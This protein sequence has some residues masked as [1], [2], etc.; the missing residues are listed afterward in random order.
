[1][2]SKDINGDYLQAKYDRYNTNEELEESVLIDL[3]YDNNILIDFDDYNINDDFYSNNDLEKAITNM[4]NNSRLSKLI[5]N[6][7]DNSLQIMEMNKY[8]VVS[9]INNEYI[10]NLNNKRSVNVVIGTINND[11]TIIKIINKPSIPDTILSIDLLLIYTNPAL[12]T[13]PSEVMWENGSMPSLQ[14]GWN[15]KILLRSYNSGET[16]VAE[17]IKKWATS[18]YRKRIVQAAGGV[19]YLDSRDVN[20]YALGVNDPLTTEWN[21]LMG[22][23]ADV[24]L[25][26]FIGSEANGWKQELVNEQILPMLSCNG[27]T[28]VGVITDPTVLSGIGYDE[29]FAIAMTFRLNPGADSS[30]LF[31]KANGSDA[32]EF[33]LRWSSSTKRIDFNV[34]NTVVRSTAPE[35][36]DAGTWANVIFHRDSTGV[37]KAYLNQKIGSS[38]GTYHTAFVNQIY[39]RLGGRVTTGGSS[40]NERLNGSIATVTVYRGALA[41]LENV[42]NT[43]VILSKPY[44][45]AAYEELAQAI[46]DSGIV[47]G[48]VVV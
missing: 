45:D 42:L 32:I 1:L 8:S 6:S 10:I 34:S 20:N 26:G 3:I 25:S 7:K 48:S 47:D 15:Y 11:D 2:L 43:E 28:G 31:S 24:T 29:Q 5:V 14:A 21:E 19:F 38:T 18:D 46:V 12:I 39:A 41:T 40:I 16:W 37:L 27:T 23:T 17:S 4:I 44:L 13:F 36:V 22:S 35:I 9:A 33:Q 30:V